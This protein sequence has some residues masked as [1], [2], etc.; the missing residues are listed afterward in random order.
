ML[1]RSS[2]KES[3]LL[4]LSRPDVE[5]PEVARVLQPGDTLRVLER[6]VMLLGGVQKAGPVTLETGDNVLDVLMRGGINDPK[7]LREVTIIRAEDLKAGR[8]KTEK[9]DLR[10]YIEKGDTSVL[11]PVYDGDVVYV[12]VPGQPGENPFNL[13]NLLWI[14][15][16]FGLGI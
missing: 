6:Q 12:E 3:L 9:H 5:L 11:V 14:G 4:D 15:R 16:I 7:K 2:L 10:P 8:Q 1:Q 13:L